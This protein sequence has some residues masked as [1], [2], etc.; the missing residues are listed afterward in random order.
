M[1]SGRAPISAAR[2]PGSGGRV[3]DVVDAG[4]PDLRT[5]LIE[6]EPVR[7]HHLIVPWTDR[8]A[9]QSGRSGADLR[10]RATIIARPSDAKKADARA[11]DGTVTS[12][13]GSAQPPVSMAKQIVAVERRRLG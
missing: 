11:V 13:S 5:H 2:R 3:E 7:A 1:S 10:A 9:A 8:H 6:H 4:R 12:A